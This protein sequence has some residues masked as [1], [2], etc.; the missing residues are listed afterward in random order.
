MREVESALTGLRDAGRSP[1]LLACRWD[2][3]PGGYVAIA[4]M[5]NALTADV[6]KGDAVVAGFT[7]IRN[8][9]G[10]L[11]VLPRV[12]RKICSN[13]MVSLDHSLTNALFEGESVGEAVERCMSR[14]EL[15]GSLERYRIAAATPIRDP[16][17]LLS[18]AEVRSSI[19]DVA[20]RFV[21]EEE[22]T[23]WG[24]VN[25]AT[26]LA[27]D[28]TDWS[29]RIDLEQDG[30]RILAVVCAR[31]GSASPAWERESVAQ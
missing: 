19:L 28:E 24:L 3:A 14:A 4:A 26:T 21:N 12:Y 13:G 10:M 30:A 1:T 31:H 2:P 29:R 6:R 11:E 7:A 27:R 8:G 22:P 23:G 5:D 16:I 25:A 20:D 9:S 18:E 17:D 15:E